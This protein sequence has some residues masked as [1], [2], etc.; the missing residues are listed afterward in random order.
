V[1]RLFNLFS[2]LLLNGLSIFFLKDSN[3]AGD[4]LYIGASC[5]FFE[6][7]SLKFHFLKENRELI[8]GRNFVEIKTV[9]V[10]V[11]DSIANI[12]LLNFPDTGTVPL[13]H[14]DFPVC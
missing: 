13:K 1:A 12:V 7:E 4:V 3:A 6:V 14:S 5:T 2:E 10:F 9:G 8:L 11:D